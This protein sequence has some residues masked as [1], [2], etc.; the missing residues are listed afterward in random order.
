M[1]CVCVCVCDRLTDSSIR[2]FTRLMLLQM[3]YC[4]SD[5]KYENNSFGVIWDTPDEGILCLFALYTVCDYDPVPACNFPRI[6]KM[7][8]SYISKNAKLPTMT[9]LMCITVLSPN[10]PDPRTRF[11]LQSISIDMIDAIIQ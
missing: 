7:P 2:W 6:C 3:A 9:N 5:L 8:V 10:A 11:K 4:R 1:V